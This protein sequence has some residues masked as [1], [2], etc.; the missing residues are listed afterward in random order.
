MTRERYEEL[1]KLTMGE[2]L[3]PYVCTNEEFDFMLESCDKSIEEL[4]FDDEPDL[5]AC[6]VKFNNIVTGEYKH[7][8]RFE[9]WDWF[10]PHEDYDPVNHGR[11][12]L[13]GKLYFN[14]DRR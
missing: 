14:T 7:L 3:E 6:G 9:W 11:I 5:Y 1:N 10:L 8:W 12:H 2:L 4:V 13:F